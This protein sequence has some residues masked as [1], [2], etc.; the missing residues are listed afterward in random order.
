VSTLHPPGTLDQLSLFCGR[1]SERT[2]RERFLEFHAENPH[3]YKAL[4]RFALEAYAAGRGRFSMR[5]IFH[6]ARWYTRI[7]TTDPDWKIN[8]RWSP[9]YAR[10]MMEA[11]PELEGFFELRELRA[12]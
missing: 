3:V 8:D 10:M 12:P 7:E 11:V 9:H 4:L 2:V 1:K 5:A 6:R